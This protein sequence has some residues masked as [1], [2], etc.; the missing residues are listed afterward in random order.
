MKKAVFIIPYFGAFNNYFQLFL[1]SCKYNSDFYWLI[2]TDDKREYDYPQNV[3]VIYKSFYEM[4][5]MIQQKFEF[6]ISLEKPYKLCD[7]KPAYGYIFESYIQDYL[8]WGHCDTDM[9]F[10]NLSRFITPEDFD[11]YD[12]IGI[13]GHCTLYRNCSTITCAFM[14]KLVDCKSYIDVFSSECNQSFDEEYSGSI[15]S[16]FEKSGFKIRKKEYEANIYTKSSLFRLTRLIESGRKYEVEKKK[17]AFFIWNRGNLY[18]YEKAEKNISQTEYMYIHLQSRYMKIHAP[19]NS[20]ILKI[21]PNAFDCPEKVNITI[22]NF[23][24]VKHKYYNFH[25]FRLR[26]ANFK[27]KV[28]RLC[29]KGKQWIYK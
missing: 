25:Y 28:F 20:N 17:K 5:V 6:T 21:I 2:F 3:T 23:K 7:F 9:I 19:Q 26:T 4:K 22:E 11:I 16:I 10:G 8:F 12:K 14:K 18:R 27:I 24:K 13:L 1:N 29:K 15:N